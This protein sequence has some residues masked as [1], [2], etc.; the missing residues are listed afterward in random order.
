MKRSKAI[1]L[2]L[3]V[4]LCASILSSYAYVAS[5]QTEPPIVD[6]ERSVKV[7]NGGIVFLNDTYTLSAPEGS[8]VL[9]SDFWVGL[10]DTFTPERSIF[11]VWESDSWTQV[12]VLAQGV[13][14][15]RGSRIEF[16]VPI[17][18]RAGKTLTF[19][20]SYLILDSV[21]GTSIS[22]AAVIPFYPII[23]YI[24]SQYQLEVELPPGA[25]F[26]RVASPINMTQVEVGDHWNVNYEG[27]NIPVHIRV[28][29]SI[30]YTRSTDDDLLLVVEDASRSI[31]VKSSNL[32]VVDSY[33]ITNKG[34]IVV[35]FP[36]ELPVDA[37]NIKARD[38]VGP[39]VTIATESNGSKEVTVFTRSP[40]MPGDRWVFSISYTTESGDHVSTT[41]GLS[42]LSYPNIELPHFIR[43]LE[44]TVSR[45]E[46][47]VVS[48]T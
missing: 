7:L 5:G 31:R 19:R 33:A 11:E 9:I 25:I 18:L 1:T 10:S 37:S 47:D 41:G 48:L 38:G 22:Y 20:A 6:V 30:I 39:I 13:Q 16:A 46:R 17:T 36:L 24:I 29:A 32:L 28:F 35:R 27:E 15:D 26:E 4:L 44:A 42:H 45:G 43:D 21:S 23:E 12:D 2:I 14:D 40:V 8:E 3:M 34:P